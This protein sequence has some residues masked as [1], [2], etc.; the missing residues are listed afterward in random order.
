MLHHRLMLETSSKREE[1]GEDQRVPHE[2]LIVISIPRDARSDF[3]FRRVIQ[4]SLWFGVLFFQQLLHGSE[5]EISV[6][7][8][9]QGSPR[10]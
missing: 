8:D 1:R 2:F 6:M 5:N 10:S 9:V 3:G 7:D 4:H